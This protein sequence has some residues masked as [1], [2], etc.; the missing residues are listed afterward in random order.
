MEKME[1]E[2]SELIEKESTSKISLQFSEK[3]GILN[4]E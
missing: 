4:Q 1:W 3:T 2:K